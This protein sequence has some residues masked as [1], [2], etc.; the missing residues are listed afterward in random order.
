M[1][2]SI[3][4]DVIKATAFTTYR[5]SRGRLLGYVSS[6]PGYG[7]VFSHRIQGEWKATTAPYEEPLYTAC[8][9]LKGTLPIS[10]RPQGRVP[11]TQEDVRTIAPP[12]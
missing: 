5:C 8:K 2:D 4:F 3:D 6:V 10:D 12:T 9:H 7:V 1:I 11:L